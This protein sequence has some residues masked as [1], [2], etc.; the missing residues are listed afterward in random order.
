MDREIFERYAARAVPRYTSYPTAP[1]LAPG[2]EERS[3][4]EWL[5]QLAP[6]AS[7]SLYL[8]IPFCRSM[9]WY[10]GCHTTVSRRQA[11]I[12]RYLDALRREVQLIAACIPHRLRVEHVHLGGGTPTLMKPDQLLA[13]MALL[14]EHFLLAEGAEI[15]IEI[16]PRTLTRG[17]AAA[18][19]K[20]GFT[21]AS[22]G[23]QCFNPDVQQAINRVQSFEETA[24]AVG[25][26]RAAG[27]GS[28]NFDLIYGLPRQTIATCIATV[29]Q[30]LALQPDRL[31]VFGYAHVP[32]FKPHQ[33]KIAAEA[34]PGASARLE[35]SRV[36]AEALR[37]AG[38][39][40]VGLDHFA[41]ADDPLAHAAAS[42]TL[43]RNF[44]GYTT[45]RAEALIGL[46]A[47]SIGRLAAGYVQNAVRI[48]QY[49]RRVAGGELPVERG[50]ATS[51][52][53]RLR[54]AIIERIMC[55]HRVDLEEVGRSFG[56]PAP[57]G[58]LDQLI[59]D[60]LVRRNGSVVE[61]VR[62]AYPLVRSVAAAFDAYLNQSAR[63]HAPAV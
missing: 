31:A 27:I 63:R 51:A 6:T 39:V 59:L 23:V 17:M 16:D 42:G 32:S 22:I 24:A 30:A 58:E 1:H 12:A 53:D 41:R 10:C 4:R 36:I 15:A 47:S 54:G 48:P 28:L 52:D 50:Y 43:G 62:E 14:R 3:Y 5:G 11:P 9:C 33:G 8:H 40:E 57:E 26:L 7:G 37:S 13:L 49:E 35:Q 25:A 34:L 29:E 45:D 56:A 2:F 19:G 44:Q 18:L 38:Y 20:A 21:R 55:D 61:V 46:G 60:G